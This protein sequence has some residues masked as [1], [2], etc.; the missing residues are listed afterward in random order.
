MQSRATFGLPRGSAHR[1]EWKLLKRCIDLPST[2]SLKRRYVEN[3]F[4]GTSWGKLA[5]QRNHH[6][7]SRTSVGAEDGFVYIFSSWRS[8]A[9]ILNH[10]ADL[11]YSSFGWAVGLEQISL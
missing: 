1:E 2:T 4:F 10:Q 6:Y 9:S 3:K 5:R 8:R 11:Q 7:T